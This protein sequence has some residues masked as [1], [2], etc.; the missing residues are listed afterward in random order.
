MATVEIRCWASFWLQKSI[1]SALFLKL[2]FF[3][4]F[5]AFWGGLGEVWEGFGRI[6]GWFW[7]GFGRF[8]EGLGRVWGEATGQNEARP[9]DRAQRLNKHRVST[10]FNPP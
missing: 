4:D 9:A 6:W 5:E 1:F 8:G 7:K 2:P 10:L 3:I